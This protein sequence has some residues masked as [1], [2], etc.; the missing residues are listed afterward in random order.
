MNES[1]TALHKGFLNRESLDVNILFLENIVV[2]MVFIPH[3][4]SVTSS[5]SHAILPFSTIFIN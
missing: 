3:I 1:I 4:N 5:S 2:S